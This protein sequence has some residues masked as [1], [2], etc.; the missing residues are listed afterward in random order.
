MGVGL[1]PGFVTTGNSWSARGTATGSTRSAPAA[2][3]TSAARSA[4][5]RITRITRIGRIGPRIRARR[6]NAAAGGPVAL[7]LQL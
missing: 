1:S 2:T 7:G 4:A 3:T 6:V 5:A